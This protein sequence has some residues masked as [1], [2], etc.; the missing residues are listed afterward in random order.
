MKKIIFHIDVNNAF[1]SWTAVY[2]LKKGYKLDIRKIPSII[3]GDE[4]K[5]HGIVLAKSPI[6][7]RMG[8]VTAE[9]IYSAKSKCKELQIYEPNFKWYYEQSNKMYDYLTQYTPTIERFSIDECFLDMT[10]TN[11]LYENY[12]ELAY[13]IKEEIKS[14][15]GFSVNV[16]IGNNKLCAKMASDFEKPDKVHTLFM[17]EIKDKMWPLPV[18]ELFMCGKKTSSNLK[19]YNIVTIGDLANADLKELKEEF[20]NQADFLKKYANGI[21][22]SEVIPRSSKSTSISVTQTLP[23]DYEDINKLKEILFIQSEEVGRQLRGQ[24]EYTNTVTVIYKNN[25]FENYTRQVRLDNST[26]KT[27]D[28]YIAATQILEKTWKKDAI[29]LIGIR[30]SNFTNK[31]ERQLS[32]FDENETENENNFQQILDDI[33]N[34]FGK[35]CVMPASI[36]KLNIHVKEKIPKKI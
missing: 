16:G 31:K 34:K 26:N 5:R 3:G 18:D 11:L 32:M 8:I 17:N 27:K 9:T 23:F 20:K 14:K 13:H 1:L 35:N 15:F 7:K 4:T 22:Y 10:G 24:K 6:A 29:R 36:K 2:L 30:I 21:D 25:K 28:I 33:N 12:V 19:K